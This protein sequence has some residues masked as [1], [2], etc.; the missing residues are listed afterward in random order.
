VIL[1]TDKPTPIPKRASAPKSEP[2]PLMFPQ[3]NRNITVADMHPFPISGDELRNLVA[4]Y[5][6]RVLH[7]IVNRAM[8]AEIVTMSEA[9]FEAFCRSV[10]EDE[11]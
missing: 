6:A 3:R 5:V 8:E 7:K 10:L 4:S 1:K 11:A 2:Q 9:E